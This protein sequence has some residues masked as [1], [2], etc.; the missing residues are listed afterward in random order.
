VSYEESR[1]E[2]LLNVVEESVTD[3]EFAK[4]VDGIS[5]SAPIRERFNALAEIANKVIPEPPYLVYGKARIEFFIVAREA[6]ETGDV[7]TLR[8]VFEKIDA[9]QPRLQKLR[10]KRR[11]VAFEQPTNEETAK[12]NLDGLMDQAVSMGGPTLSPQEVAQSIVRV[13]DAQLG[14]RFHR[15]ATSKELL[16]SLKDQEQMIE[17]LR[18]IA[19]QRAKTE[20]N[21]LQ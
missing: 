3:E 9:E 8:K 17:C 1:Y 20:R 15:P 13:M 4:I 18:E 14:Q 7:G 5:D 16:S 21:D 19:S 10:D 12:E 6:A 11:A 2:A